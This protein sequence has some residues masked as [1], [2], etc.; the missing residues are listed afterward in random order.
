MSEFVYI[1]SNPSYPK[2]YKVGYTTTSV[3]QRMNELFTTGVPSRFI[4]EFCIEVNNGFETE[5]YLHKTLEKYKHQKEFFN[6]DLHDLIRICKV[7]LFKGEIDFIQYFGKANNFYLTETE[8]NEIKA[9]I[10]EKKEIALRR[11][12]QKQAELDRKKAK[13]IAEKIIYERLT[14][15][16]VTLLYEINQIILKRSTYLNTNVLKRLFLT[17]HFEDGKKIAKFLSIDEIEKVMKLHSIITE[18]NKESNNIQKFILYKGQDFKEKVKLV[19][20]IDEIS[21][22]DFKKQK[23]FRLKYLGIS[24][25]YR[26]MLSYLRIN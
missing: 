2:L 25:F 23:Q 21:F 24:D 17:N 8:I 16:F 6:I 15:N 4:L 20:L 9:K 14:E 13:E 12:E 22:T 10:K 1:L 11:K 26:G 3:E 18:L 19:I 7:E 5:Q